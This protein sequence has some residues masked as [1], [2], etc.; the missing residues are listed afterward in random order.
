MGHL[1]G[2]TLGTPDR[3]GGS[4]FG[5]PFLGSLFS[6][7]L[8]YILLVG[9]VGSAGLFSDRWFWMVPTESGLELP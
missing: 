4:V 3:L 9:L 7:C 2:C 8:S 5:I 6:D 1:G